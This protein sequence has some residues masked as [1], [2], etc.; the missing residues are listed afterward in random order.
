M[1]DIKTNVHI[2]NQT[3]VLCIAFWEW[4]YLQQSRAWLKNSN[5]WSI[6]YKKTAIDLAFL[7]LETRILSG[8]SAVHLHSRLRAGHGVTPCVI[9]FSR[10]NGVCIPHRCRKGSFQTFCTIMLQI[11]I[12]QTIF[13]LKLQ[14]VQSIIDYCVC[15]LNLHLNL[16]STLQWYRMSRLEEGLSDWLVVAPSVTDKEDQ[17]DPHRESF[18]T[19]FWMRQI[20]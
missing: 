17:L 1:C 7:S 19:V 11:V 12:D 3:R 16:K 5:Q 2:N 20:N 6:V 13:I 8:L 9:L 4:V 10:K 18:S 14:M 15:N